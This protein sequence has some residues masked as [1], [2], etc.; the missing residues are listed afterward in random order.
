MRVAFQ[1]NGKPVETE[2]E[3]GMNVLEFLRSLGVFSVKHGCDHGECG[4]CTVLV[5]DKPQNACLMLMGTLDGERIETLEGLNARRRMELMQAAFLDEG[6][7][8]CGYCTPAMLLALESLLRAN[9]KPDEA[10]I[11]EVF[12]GI[13]CRCTGYVKPMVAAKKVA[14]G[15]VDG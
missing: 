10:A 7:I 15:E 11:R 1:L 3:P 5:D 6:A 14:L 8:Q 9:P 12:S 13:Y 2:V 4:S